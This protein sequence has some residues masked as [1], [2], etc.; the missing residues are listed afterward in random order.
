M[1]KSPPL[2][3]ATPLAR[4][5]VHDAIED[6]PDEFFVTIS[7]PPRKRRQENLFWAR[8][9]ELARTLKWHG[10]HWTK[11]AWADFFFAAWKEERG[12]AYSFMPGMFNT[13]VK[14]GRATS[15]L[16]E[17]DYGEMLTLQ[18]VFMAGQQVAA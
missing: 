9:G 12:E 7:P 4:D 3:L 17:D 10:K 16:S 5:R 8:N 2:P 15:S 1:K 14:L 18:D 11:E 6:A 13:P